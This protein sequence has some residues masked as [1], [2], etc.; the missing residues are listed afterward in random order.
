MKKLSSILFILLLSWGAYSQDPSFFHQVPQDPSLYTNGQLTD[1]T[2]PKFIETA[3][4]NNPKFPEFK[5]ASC[6]SATNI[7]GQGGFF[8][9][10][11][12]SLTS[13]CAGPSKS[14]II[15]EPVH[16]LSESSRLHEIANFPGMNVM[17][18]PNQQEGLPTLAAPVAYLSY[19][20]MGM[21][22]YLV[23]MPL[24]AGKM[25][26]DVIN[27]YK[28]K[29]DKPDIARAYRRLGKEM[30]NFQNR[31]MVNDDP[32]VLL[33]KS[34]QH[35]DM[36]CLNIFY[37]EKTNHFTFI[38]NEFMQ[39]SLNN[40]QI[41]QMDNFRLL[42]G[43]LYQGEEPKIARNLDG[44]DLK[45]WY[46]LTV[47]SFVEGYVEVFPENQRAQ[48]LEELRNLI[49]PN[50][51]PS[52]AIPAWLEIKAMY[53]NPIFDELKLKYAGTGK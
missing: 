3:F 15:K 42:F 41:R 30:A 2:I 52:I 9:K 22:H 4:L 34:L 53:I 18:E 46:N 32:K 35:G 36:K 29:P 27:D 38:D 50:Q 51:L 1:A 23:V 14:Y 25:L 39:L 10:Q 16:G 48:V 45:T 37:D 49:D 43:N 33:G 6:L 12:F 8:T 11:L 26:C 24:A 5:S 31:F 40:R 21:K 47:K 19:E 20:A 7:R 44:I 17:I 28:T 13:T